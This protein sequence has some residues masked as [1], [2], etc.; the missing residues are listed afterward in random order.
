MN[1][2]TI[3]LLLALTAASCASDAS[4]QRLGALHSACAT[5]DQQACQLVPIQEETNRQEANANAGKVALG[6]LTG[7]LLIGLFAWAASTENGHEHS[8]HN[9]GGFGHGGFGHR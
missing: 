9:H 6:I 3:S 5:G 8:F 2:R 7:A 4:I 1:Q